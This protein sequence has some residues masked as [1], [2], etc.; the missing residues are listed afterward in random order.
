[1]LPQ[2]AWALPQ[3][4]WALPQAPWALPRAAWRQNRRR[5]EDPK[6]ASVPSVQKT[7]VILRHDELNL[8]HSDKWVTWHSSHGKTFPTLT[9][10]RLDATQSRTKSTSP[11]KSITNVIRNLH[12][13]ERN[14]TPVLRSVGHNRSSNT[15]LATSANRQ[16]TLAHWRGTARSRRNP[17][18][19]RSSSCGAARFFAGLKFFFFLGIFACSDYT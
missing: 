16:C 11:T 7:V 9:L 6:R 8:P 19:P 14:R 10:N 13:F 15:G 18:P 12:I 5:R 17:P 2:A 3:A 1:V 4:P